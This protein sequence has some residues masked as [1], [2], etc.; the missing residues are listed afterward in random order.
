MLKTSQL[1]DLAS[2]TGPR[3]EPVPVELPTEHELLDIAESFGMT[4]SS[5]DAASF[6]D[7]MRGAIGSYNRLDEI[8]EPTLPVKYPRSAGHRPSAAENPFNAWYWKSEIKGATHGV[9]AGRRLAVKDNILRRGRADDERL[10]LAR[11]LH[12]GGRRDRGHPRA[13]RRR[14]G[15]R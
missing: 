15:R 5:S 9:L 13:R 3:G 12:A 11:G 14:G 7:L 2:H 8:P 4:L 10:A 6:R 1:P